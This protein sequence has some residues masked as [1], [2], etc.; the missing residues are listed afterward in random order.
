MKSPCGSQGGGRKRAVVAGSMVYR[1][2]VAAMD[3]PH[4]AAFSAAMAAAEAIDDN[5]GYNHIAGFHGAPD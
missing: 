4:M 3:T 1:L 5:R 2:Q